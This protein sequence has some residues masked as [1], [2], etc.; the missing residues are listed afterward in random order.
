V[1]DSHGL[2]GDVI[3]SHESLVRNIL[4]WKFST[5]ASFVVVTSDTIFQSTQIWYA[6]RI[7]VRTYD[8]LMAYCSKVFLETLHDLRPI[9]H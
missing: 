8:M 5:Q 9:L 1:I 2:K 3:F 4:T 6:M 7:Q